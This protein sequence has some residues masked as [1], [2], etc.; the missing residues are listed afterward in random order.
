M[1]YAKD[2]S[3]SNTADKISAFASN[4]TPFLFLIDFDGAGEVYTLEE[5]AARGIYFSFHGSRPQKSALFSSQST[6]FPPPH[7]SLLKATPVSFQLYQ[8]AFDQI[9]HHLQRGDT[10]LINL[11]FET[12]IETPCSLQQIFRYSDAPY[13]LLYGNRFVVF[14][15]ERFIKISKGVIETNPMK[16][17]IDAAVA[18]AEASL[19]ADPKEHYEHNTIVDLLRNDINMVATDVT[20]EKFRYI[21]KI[22]THK[23]ELLQASSLITGKLPD[24]YLQ[25][26]GTIITTLLPAGSVT[27]APKER[28]VEIIRAAENYRRGHYTGIFGYFDGKDL[29]VAVAIRF[30][31]QRNGRYFFKSGGGITALSNARDEYEEMINKVYLPWSRNTLA[32]Q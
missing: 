11:T 32:S 9:M 3:L 8:R 22:A 5:A 17:T 4:G 14:S 6:A 23:G 27:G 26:L 24:D 31:E 1:T 18:D 10:Y 12:E 7:S 16:G 2:E 29:D 30:I 20:V 25:H 13:K 21:E 15:P 19:L 28:T